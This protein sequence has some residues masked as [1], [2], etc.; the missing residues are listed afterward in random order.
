MAGPGDERAAT[1]AS[2]GQWLGKLKCFL[3]RHD[4]VQDHWDRPRGGPP[5][6]TQT[7]ARC[8]K[9]RDPDALMRGAPWISGP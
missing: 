4:Y 1:A 5:P 3:E 2:R 9:R 6:R 8:G 7:C